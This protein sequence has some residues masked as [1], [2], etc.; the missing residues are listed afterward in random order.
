MSERAKFLVTGG[1]GSIGQ[2]VVRNLLERG[3][4]SVAADRSADV[5][6][7]ASLR[8]VAGRTDAAFGSVLMEVR[9]FRDVM[10]CPRVTN[11][12]RSPATQSK[13]SRGDSCRVPARLA[14]AN[15]R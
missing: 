8:I 14:G 5:E 3:I 1:L 11:G 6:A 4:P 7:L 10:A 15:R 2:L 13:E 12:P 9:D